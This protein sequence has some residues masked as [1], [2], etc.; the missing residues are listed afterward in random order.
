MEKTEQEKFLEQFSQPEHNDPFAEI[1]APVEG[2]PQ[3]K[4]ED[5]EADE[6]K[7]RNRRERRLAAKLQ[8]EREA[9]IEM[10]ARLKALTEAQNSRETASSSADHLAQIER[11]YGTESPE[12]RE[13]TELLK[14]SL[15]AVEDRAME[16]A[17]ERLREEQSKANEEVVKA[18]RMLDSMMEEIEDEYEA[19]LSNEKVRSGF[20]TLLQ[21]MSPKDKEG[22]IIQY[23]D[24]HAVWEMYQSRQTSTTDTRARDLA[25]RTMVQS[26]SS[27]E[28]KIQEDATVRYLRENG[29]I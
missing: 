10:A 8:A 16:R 21:K 24:H 28:S 27:P 15:K 6:T 5:Q 12:A 11:I 20:L 25:A 1:I 19:D 4:E 14:S 13:A 2:E 17:L 7:L 23:A 22:N 3:K 26:G 9:G 29:I 18:E